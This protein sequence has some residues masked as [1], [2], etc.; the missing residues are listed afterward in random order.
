MPMIFK[1]IVTFTAMLLAL[2]AIGLLLF[3]A[4]MLSVVGIASDARTDF[5]LRASGVGV[6]A[7]VPGL[8]ASRNSDGSPVSRAVL[9][10]IV[11]YMFLS[12]IVDLHAYTQ[13]IVNVASLPS[14]AFR[15]ALGALI[16]AFVIR[17]STTVNST[18]RTRSRNRIEK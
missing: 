8:W 15:L 18:E 16:L 14:I 11:I 13:S 12:S 9:V 1:G 10:G 4:N 17:Q 6:V 3:P 5:L 2:S 7:L